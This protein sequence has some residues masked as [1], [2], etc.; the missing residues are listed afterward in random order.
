MAGNTQ[1][2]Q[3]KERKLS[4][5]ERLESL[6]PYQMLLYLGIAAST[7]VFVFMMVAFSV[8]VLA[9]H[10]AMNIILPK[11]FTLSSIIIVF[12]GFYVSRLVRKFRKEDMDGLFR[13]LQVTSILGLVFGMCQILGWFFLYHDNAT[14]QTDLSAAYLYVIS[15]LHLLHLVGGMIYI[16][17][18][19]VQLFAKMGDEVK[20]LIYFTD[21]FQK[22]KLN[23]LTIYW[24][25]LEISWLIIFLWFFV[26]F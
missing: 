16:S 10:D 4:T 24:R 3:L 15:G 23:L 12:S 18:L 26:L 14:L 6:H 13:Y 22:L 20:E 21:K 1:H 8:R 5:I 2:Q 17:V 11:P 7:L 9:G 19:N 25:F